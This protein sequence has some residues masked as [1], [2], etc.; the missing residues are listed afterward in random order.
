MSTGSLDLDLM[1][2]NVRLTNANAAEVESRIAVGKAIGRASAER[3]VAQARLLNA[4]AAEV[5]ARAQ[6]AEA[7]SS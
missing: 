3:E 1:K 4:Q 7:A 2:A 5:E 6:E